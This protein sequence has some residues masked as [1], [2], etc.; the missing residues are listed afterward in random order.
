MHKSMNVLNKFPKSSQPKVK[1]MLHDIWKAETRKS[2][3]KAFDLFVKTYETKFPDAVALRHKDRAELLAFY[4]FPAMHWQSIRTTNPIESAFATIRHRTKRSKSC[5]ARD[6]MLHM[7]FKLGQCAQQNW[8]KLPGF[9]HLAE[10]I[11][12]IGFK[13][14]IKQPQQE[15]TAA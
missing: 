11:E 5:L 14:G 2:A 15:T 13:D 1:A 12:G 3:E 7:K 9:N 10:V 6:G 4:D 8:R